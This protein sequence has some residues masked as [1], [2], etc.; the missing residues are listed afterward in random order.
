[1]DSEEAAFPHAL[2][3]EEDEVEDDCSTCHESLFH[4]VLQTEWEDC[5]DCHEPDEIR[6]PESDSAVLWRPGTPAEHALA[7]RLHRQVR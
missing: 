3:F 4:Q 6:L 7:A 2:H 5:L 1:M